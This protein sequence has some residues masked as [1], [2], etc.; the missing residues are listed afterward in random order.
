MSSVPGWDRGGNIASPYQSFDGTNAADGCHTWSPSEAEDR[1]H[2]NGVSNL[3]TISLSVDVFKCRIWLHF[4]QFL[5]GTEQ[6]G[7]HGR[8][9]VG[10]TV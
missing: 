10:S 3:S 7:R 4:L 1:M 5:A 6:L 9:E 8:G 2:E